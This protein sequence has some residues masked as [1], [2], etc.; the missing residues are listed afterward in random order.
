MYLQQI[1][2]IGIGAEIRRALRSPAQH[3]QRKNLRIPVVLVHPF[4]GS[5]RNFAYLQMRRYRGTQNQA[6][7]AQNQMQ[8]RSI[9]SNRNHL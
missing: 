2:S 3:C 8:D 4:I 5:I 9:G 6:L 7:S 1:R